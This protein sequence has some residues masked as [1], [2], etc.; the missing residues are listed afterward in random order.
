M[1]FQ[2]CYSGWA[3]ILSRKAFVVIIFILNVLH[4]QS[5]SPSRFEPPLIARLS[6]PAISVPLSFTT[7]GG[8]HNDFSSWR[9][10]FRDPGSDGFKSGFRLLPQML[11]LWNPIFVIEIKKISIFFLILIPSWKQKSI[12]TSPECIKM[13]CV[14]VHVGRVLWHT[15]LYSICT[16]AYR[17]KD[18]HLGRCPHSQTTPSS[19][20]A[21]V[22]KS[23]DGSSPSLYS[24]GRTAPT[25]KSCVIWLEDKRGP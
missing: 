6:L 5:S 10:E 12:P 13:F 16:T 15:H 8:L 25:H 11:V 3:T 1:L 18:I 2:S 4:Q 20:F 7:T 24:A 21:K 19:V 9:H 23:A 22:L 17:K 14:R